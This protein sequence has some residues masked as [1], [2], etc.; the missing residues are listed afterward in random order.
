ML[1]LC[2]FLHGYLYLFAL[3][4]HHFLEDPHL[5]V[6]VITLCLKSLDLLV[7]QPVPNEDF[8]V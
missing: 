1:H 3:S 7:V 2:L 4:L 8:I 5:L 6:E